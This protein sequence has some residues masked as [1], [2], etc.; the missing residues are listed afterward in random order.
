MLIEKILD[1]IETIS[2]NSYKRS[3]MPKNDENSQ[4]ITETDQPK[5]F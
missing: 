2:N 5:L 3:T 1:K 4:L